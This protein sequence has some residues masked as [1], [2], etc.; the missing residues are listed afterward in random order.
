MNHAFTH[1]YTAL[2]VPGRDDNDAGVWFV[3]DTD[4]RRTVRRAIDADDANRGADVMNGSPSLDRRATTLTAGDTVRGDIAGGGLP[5]RLVGEN[6]RVV[7][8]GRVTVYVRF[9]GVAYT[10]ARPH[11]TVR[12]ENLIDIGVQS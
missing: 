7:G 8:H 9:F 1:R 3:F 12:R 6:G 4:T 2:H 5:L 10:D 11:H